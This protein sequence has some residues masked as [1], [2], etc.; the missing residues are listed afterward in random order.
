MQAVNWWINTFYP[1]NKNFIIKI[2]I[3]QYFRTDDS[4]SHERNLEFF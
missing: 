2:K 1:D 3:L 4:L